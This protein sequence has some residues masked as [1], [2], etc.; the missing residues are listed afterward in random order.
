MSGFGA[1]SSGGGI[2][3]LGMGTVFASFAGGVDSGVCEAQASKKK[4][5]S[6]PML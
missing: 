4:S 3:F 1:R 6:S 2:C 5:I